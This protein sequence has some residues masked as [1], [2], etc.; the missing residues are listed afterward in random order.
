MYVPMSPIG[1]NMAW[2]LKVMEVG[3]KQVPAPAPVKKI[4]T[5]FIR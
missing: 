5:N 4:V 3:T 2:L 1:R